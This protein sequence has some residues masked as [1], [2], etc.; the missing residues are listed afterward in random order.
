MW[1]RGVQVVHRS[2][3]TCIARNHVDN[4][5]CAMKAATFTRA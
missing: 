5:I 2:A 3:V 1:M 4:V